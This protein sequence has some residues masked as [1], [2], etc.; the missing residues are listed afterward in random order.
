VCCATGREETIDCPPDCE[1]LREAHRHEKQQPLDVSKLPN[2]DIEITEEFLKEHEILLAFTAIAVYEGAT[3]SGAATDWDVREALESLV[4]VYRALKSGLYI[5]PA[6][7]N[8]YASAIVSGVQEAI[9]VIRAQE[10]EKTGTTTIRDAAL[11]GVMAFLQRLEY[12]HNNGRRR[13]R[14][15]I[16]FL[17]DFYTAEEEQEEEPEPGEEPL[18]LL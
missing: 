12:S 15:F 17:S 8:P 18:I 1:Y 5:E 7:A 4:A 2:Q 9:E 6:L 13:C 14:A 16:D 3:E 10:R 11:L